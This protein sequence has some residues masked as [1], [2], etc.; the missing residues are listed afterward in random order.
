MRSIP[1]VQKFGQQSSTISITPNAKMSYQLE[2]L[3]QRYKTSQQAVLQGALDVFST[4]SDELT[5]GNTIVTAV[6]KRGHQKPFGPETGDKF[7]Y[8]S[9]YNPQS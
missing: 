2:T 6:P 8:F 1:S 3:Q 5:Q 7:L 4:V 9:L